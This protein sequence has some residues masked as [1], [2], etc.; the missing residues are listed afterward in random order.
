MTETPQPE[1][2]I[3]EI[4]STSDDRLWALLAY[5]FTPLIP[6]LLLLL[7]EKKDRPFIKAHNMQALVLGVAAWTINFLLSFVFI[8]ICTGFL[9]LVLVIYYGV[10][11]YKGEVFE[12][13]VITK[14]VQNQGWA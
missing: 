7:E 5:I 11:A 9:T 3:H 4:E 2:V 12:I 6:I 13:P 14:F 10:K 1:I 8:G